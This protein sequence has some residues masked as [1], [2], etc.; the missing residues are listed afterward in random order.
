MNRATQAAKTVTV[1]LKHQNHIYEAVIDGTALNR[2]YR[3]VVIFEHKDKAKLVR[4]VGAWDIHNKSIV[5]CPADMPK[6]VCE[7]LARRLA[8]DADLSAA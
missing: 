5:S 2:R 3:R 4:G 8:R 6:G 7:K 1:K